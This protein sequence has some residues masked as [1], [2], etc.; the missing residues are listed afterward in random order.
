MLEVVSAIFGIIGIGFLA[1][2]FRLLS[3]EAF[4]ALNDYVYF[5]AMPALIFAKLSSV[6]IG[7]EYGVLIV[8]NLLPMLAAIAASFFLWK[9][10]V[11]DGKAASVLLLTSF[12][13]NIIYMGFPAVQMKFGA[14]ALPVASVV[15][16][17]YNIVMFGPAIILVM[18]MTKSKDNEL[19]KER[20]LKNTVILSCILGAAFSFLGLAIPAFIFK[21]IE[22]VGGTT[23]PVALFSLGLFLSIKCQIPLLPSLAISAA[24]LVFFPAIFILASALVGFDGKMF[25]I[26]LLQA[27]MPVGVTNFVLAT[28][29]GLNEKIVAGAIFASTLLSLPALA[30]FEL[31]F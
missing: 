27:M 25:Q 17:V 9:G 28:K 24:K 6:H 20:L 21:I 15:A 8:A 23:A 4:Q 30:L 2:Y 10:G 7:A 13:G 1:G 26:S 31:F 22:G 11:L 19:A 3:K 29:L 12:F 14:D 16:F 5:V 18:K